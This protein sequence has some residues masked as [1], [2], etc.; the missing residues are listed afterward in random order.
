MSFYYRKCNRCLKNIPKANADVYEL[1]KNIMFRTEDILKLED[2]CGR[3]FTAFQNGE[4][5]DIQQYL[6]NNDGIQTC[7]IK[8]ILPLYVACY[9]G[10]TDIVKILLENYEEKFTEDEHSPYQLNHKKENCTI[11]QQLL[12]M[13]AYGLGGDRSLFE[14]VIFSPLHI[15]CQKGNRDVVD[16]LLKNG[17]DVNLCSADGTCP[18]YLA[19]QEGHAGTVLHMLLERNVDV[20][21]R[22]NAGKSPLHVACLK[23]QIDIVKY[24]LIK[25][26]NINVRDNKENSPLDLALDHGWI[27]LAQFLKD[28]GAT[29]KH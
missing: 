21:H 20:D 25:G 14:M 29:S 12:N 23:N 4:V 7:I 27:D 6:S 22:N 1:L 10:H 28:K 13:N 2:I 15:A 5:N 8:Q 3:L 24:L 9:K 16:Y 26:A 19:C 17:A 11:V 18:L